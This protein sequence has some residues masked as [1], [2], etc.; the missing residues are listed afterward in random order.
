MKNLILSILMLTSLTIQAQAQLKVMTKTGQAS[1]FSTAPLED[2]EAHNHQV[3]AILDLSKNEIAVKMLIKQFNFEKSLMQEHFNENYMESDKYPSASFVGK[4]VDA[5]EIELG[6]SKTY[7]VKVVGELEI[8]GVKKA[9]ET[10]AELVVDGQDITGKTQ[11]KVALADH[12]IEIPKL[13][14]KNIAEVVDVNI[15]L[16]F[17]QTDS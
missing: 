13:V 16:N 3:V 5:P 4:I 9:I 1:F 8:H 10:T 12:E 15:E 17:K 11:F 2:I 6:V 14:V 7:E